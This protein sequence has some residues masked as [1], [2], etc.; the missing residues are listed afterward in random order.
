MSLE[1]IAYHRLQSSAAAALL[2]DPEFLDATPNGLVFHCSVELERL[3]DD[4]RVLVCFVRRN[5]VLFYNVMMLRNATLLLA[6]PLSTSQSS[7]A[8]RR[9]VGACPVHPNLLRLISSFQLGSAPHWVETKL[10]EKSRI[11]ESS[12]TESI[13]SWSAAVANLQSS[14]RWFIAP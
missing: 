14:E 3:P 1:S 2:K 9:S 8:W 11:A 13:A 4:F 10:L 7:E 12:D 6:G 5:S